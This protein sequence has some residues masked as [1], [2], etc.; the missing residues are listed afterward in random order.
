MTKKPTKG[1]TITKFMIE[2]DELTHAVMKESAKNSGVTLAQFYV[3]AAILG[4]SEA[5]K[6]LVK[7]KD[8]LQDA[9]IKELDK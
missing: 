8:M 3:Y 7:H 5:E 4:Q 2:V 1:K 6:V 9:M